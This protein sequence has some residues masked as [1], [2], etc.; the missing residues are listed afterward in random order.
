MSD[1]VAAVRF[2]DVLAGLLNE[3]GAQPVTSTSSTVGSTEDDEWLVDL[4]TPPAKKTKS[5]HISDDKEATE[6]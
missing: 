3:S 5:E 2:Q 1:S 4:L 6:W